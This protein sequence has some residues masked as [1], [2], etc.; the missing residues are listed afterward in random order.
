MEFFETQRTRRCVVRIRFRNR[1]SA[2]NRKDGP[3][4]PSCMSSM[5]KSKV[6]MIHWGVK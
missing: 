5:G 6:T 4:G 3:E 2:G 1:A